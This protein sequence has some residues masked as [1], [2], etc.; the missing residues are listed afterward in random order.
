MSDMPDFWGTPGDEI[1]A[2]S[3][4]D[5]RN[6]GKMSREILANNPGQGVAVD[7]RVY[8]SACSPGADAKAVWYRASM[9]GMLQ[10]LPESPL[11]PWL[12]DGELDD[13]VFQVAAVFP[14]KK[15][16][17]GVVHHGPPFDLQEFVKQ[18]GAGTSTAG[19]S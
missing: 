4:D 17:V 8:E 10:I 16:E 3:P 1:A 9:L 15:M 7:G 12:H 19:D 18:I 5:L 6:V 11:T 13:A 14:M 2:V